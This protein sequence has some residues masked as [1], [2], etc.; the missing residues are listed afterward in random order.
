M[1][2]L[3]ERKV[4]DLLGDLE[5]GNLDFESVSGGEYIHRIF[6]IYRIAREAAKLGDA[7][8]APII[9]RSA[10]LNQSQRLFAL[11]L[12][13]HHPL[14]E[15]FDFVFAQAARGEQL[16]R[17]QAVRVMSMLRDPSTRNLLESL[18]QD[19]DSSVR[20]EALTGLNQGDEALSLETVLPAL[21]DK[22]AST[23]R[24]A[25]KSV[26][27][28]SG[29]KTTN[30]LLDMI[31]DPQMGVAFEAK[32]ALQQRLQ[33]HDLLP[34]LIYALGR[35][36]RYT[37]QYAVE[38]MDKSKD[39]RMIDAL[40]E[41]FTICENKALRTQIIKILAKSGQPEALPVL[42]AGLRDKAREVVEASLRGLK[43]IPNEGNLDQLAV[44]AK[45]LSEVDY[46]SK[47]FEV[48]DMLV[49]AVS[50]IK[51]EKS[52]E[53]LYDLAT[54]YTVEITQAALKALQ[55][56]KLS[57]DPSVFKARL[58]NTKDPRDFD[59]LLSAYL[60]TRPDGI[61]LDSIS[62]PVK[63]TTPAGAER[64]EESKTGFREIGQ[65]ELEAMSD[66]DALEYLGHWAAHEGRDASSAVHRLKRI[67]GGEAILILR[68]ILRHKD[69]YSRAFAGKALVERGYAGLD[70]RDRAAIAVVFRDQEEL[71]ATG[72]VGI[73]VMAPLMAAGQ[74]SLIR[75]EMLNLFWESGHPERVD[76]AI[77]LV[78]G[79]QGDR[80]DKAAFSLLKGAK[81]EAEKKVLAAFTGRNNP[82]IRKETAKLLGHYKTIEAVEALIQAFQQDAYMLVSCSEA[83][84][85]IKDEKAVAPL[86]EAL[87][88][89]EE[90]PPLSSVLNALQRL[91][92]NRAIPTLKQLE[93]K[94]PRLQKKRDQV[95]KKLTSLR[96]GI[97]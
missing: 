39:P 80:T 76:A 50:A 77:R 53:L 96:C 97:S 47:P 61:D 66:V 58:S 34:D 81:D 40:T 20:K 82:G 46:M 28:M 4:I 44:Y 16:T 18:A 74:T 22:D 83:L 64:E 89:A 48:E 25:V 95:V 70:A 67:E 59:N 56:R 32:R 51:S 31:A 90:G 27:K 63:K 62:R 26:S 35:K 8:I 55:K 23:R 9:A 36:G 75:V 52:N 71:V 1:A 17:C 11:L 86:I 68:K 5:E 72:A 85:K 38:L 14:P 49:S 21:S 54:Y 41:H 87:S 6:E 15:A 12:L 84:G 94:R 7:A 69:I 33:D 93:I 79:Y 73:D 65:L 37:R 13:Q 30:I 29:T 3:T 78:S 57:I 88:W 10:D 91:K 92:A 2:S 45:N 43:K 19:E 24:E 60:D 42:W